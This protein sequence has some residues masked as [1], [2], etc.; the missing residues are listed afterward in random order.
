MTRRRSKGTD[1]LLTSKEWRGPIRQHWIRAALPCARCGEQIQYGARRYIPGTRKVN[2]R[3]LVVG[4]IV[5]RH[6]G[7]IRG[8][9]DAQINSL[10]NT[11]PECARCSDRSGAVYGNRLRGPGLHVVGTV[12]PQVDNS[13]E[14]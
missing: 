1:P 7:K 13:R 6:E 4:H 9:T 8:W 3:S 14:W 5:G 11:Q 2:P 12:V 10:E